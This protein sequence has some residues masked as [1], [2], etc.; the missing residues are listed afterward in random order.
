MAV[1]FLLDVLVTGGLSG[2]VPSTPKSESNYWA[3][4]DKI[5]VDFNMGLTSRY[6]EVQYLNNEH[7]EVN[8]H[9]IDLSLKIFPFKSQYFFASIGGQYL[10]NSINNTDVKLTN[11]STSLGLEF[12]YFGIYTTMGTND[13]ENLYSSTLESNELGINTYLKLFDDLSLHFG[14]TDLKMWEKGS[15]SGSK[16]EYTGTSYNTSL[17]FNF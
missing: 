8:L 15:P 1:G 3:D 7:K 12:N 10:I 9:G 6:L 13:V 5:R 4:D 2:I 11:F 16:I 14:I 17:I